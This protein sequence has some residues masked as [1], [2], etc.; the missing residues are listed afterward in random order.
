ML[1]FG[2][3]YLFSE[4]RGPDLED[5]ACFRGHLPRFFKRCVAALRETAKDAVAKVTQLQPNL[6][7]AFLAQGY[8][9]YYCEQNYD[10]AIAL[11]PAELKYARALTRASHAQATANFRS[12]FAASLKSSTAASLLL[13]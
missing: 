11:L 2:A 6:G 4:R 10:G 7:E 8:F 9:H 13:S 5:I 1:N 12:S 3:T